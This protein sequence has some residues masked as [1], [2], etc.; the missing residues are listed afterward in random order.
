MTDAT[1][2]TYIHLPDG[3]RLAYAEYGEKQGLPLFLL[4]GLPGSRLS[5]GLLP[6]H[7]FPDG[8]RIIAPDRPGYGRSDPNPRRTLL[9][10]SNDIEV[11]A[12]ALDIQNFA[13]VG[14]SGGGPGA[15]ACAWKMQERIL[16]A[17]IVASPAP[18][19]AAGIFEGIS[20]TNRFF[21]K[22][23]W[24]LPWLSDLNIRLLGLVIRKNPER[25]IKSMQ[26]KVDKIDQNLLKHPEISE[27]LVKDFTEA[28]LN[29][30]QGMVD[31]MSANH[32]HSWGFSLDHI[33]TKVHFWYG[34]VDRSA[35]V[36]MGQYLSSTVPNSQMTVIPDAGHLWVLVH[37]NEVLEDIKQRMMKLR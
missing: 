17:S 20:K 23:A 6:N 2:D 35:S 15:L 4:H 12:D 26:F 18:T 25:Y 21:M 37:L 32:G 16:A 28:L 27:M 1:K 14:V 11:L 5:W 36:A 13:I 10:W 29:G 24:Y 19:N 8:L 33:N 3:R 31:D 30:S 34:E 9:D 7:P 22:L